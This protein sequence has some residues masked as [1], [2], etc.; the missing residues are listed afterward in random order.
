[1]SNNKLFVITGGPGSGKTTLLLELEQKGFRCSLKVAAS[2]DALPWANTLRYAELML[3]GSIAA[4]R[5][6]TPSS[7]I[8]FMDRG[9]PDV[10]CYARFIGLPVF[11]DLKNACQEYRYKQ[12]YA[13]A[14]AIYEK[15]AEVYQEYG[16]RPIELPKASPLQRA[17]FV[18]SRN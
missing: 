4:Y 17:E 8:V 6:N 16:Y 5:E 3:A 12:T 14:V 11:D 2:G 7:E 13:E 15:M 18:L 1:L 10:A 9:I